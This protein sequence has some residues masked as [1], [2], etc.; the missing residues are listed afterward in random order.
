M[1]SMSTP[2]IGI[3]GS[4]SISARTVHVDGVVNVDQRMINVDGTAVDMDVRVDADWLCLVE[5]RVDYM[6]TSSQAL[7]AG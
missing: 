1:E 4:G 5:L 2:P 6:S 3:D 7:D